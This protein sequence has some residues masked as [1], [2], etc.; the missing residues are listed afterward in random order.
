MLGGLHGR[1]VLFVAVVVAV[2]LVVFVGLE[3][4]LRE[5]LLV[6]KIESETSNKCFAATPKTIGVVVAVQY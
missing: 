5:D 2:L 1:C 4:L 3:V 6:Q